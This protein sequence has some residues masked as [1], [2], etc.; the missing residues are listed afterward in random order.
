MAVQRGVS[1]DQHPEAH[2]PVTL[3]G[4]G[5]IVTALAN[6]GECGLG[7]WPHVVG[8]HGREEAHGA[9]GVGHHRP[10]LHEGVGELGGQRRVALDTDRHGGGFLRGL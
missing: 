5:Q 4:H 3:Q 2:R 9:A 7:R 1:G 10:Q 6:A 8:A